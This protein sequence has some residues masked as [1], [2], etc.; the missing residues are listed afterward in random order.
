MLYD[1][2]NGLVP[3]RV[4]RIHMGSQIRIDRWGY[5]AGSGAYDVIGCYS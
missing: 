5:P 4:N 2:A 3:K 1:Q